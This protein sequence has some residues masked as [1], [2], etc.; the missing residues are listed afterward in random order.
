MIVLLF[1]LYNKTEYKFN[2]FMFRAI[3]KNTFI[4][5]IMHSRYNSNLKSFGIR[6]IY[7][8][9]PVNDSESDLKYGLDSPV[10]CYK[11]RLI[12]LYC[13][14]IFVLSLLTNAIL[15]RIFYLRKKTRSSLEISMIALTMFNFFGTL[16]ELPFVITS[17][18]YCK[19]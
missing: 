12:A 14:F 2:F 16:V 17:N 7:P 4:F 11:L 13:I 1:F 3:L 9:K 18:L 10:E 19:Y 15:L 8:N 5:R 6:V